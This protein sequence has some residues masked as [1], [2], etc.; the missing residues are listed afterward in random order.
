MKILVLGASG[1]LGSTVIRYLLENDYD[2]HGTVRGSS[3][4]DLFPA[5][6]KKFIHGDVV[7]EDFEGILRLI[8]KIKPSIVINCIG[9]IKQ[10][11]DSFDPLIA[12]PINSLLPHKLARLCDLEGVR[13]IHI[14]TDCVFSGRKGG[15][16]EIDFP[17]ANDLYGRSK[18]LGEVDCH[19]CITLRTSI[20]GHEL[21][22][23]NSL[24]DWFLSQNTSV[25]GYT[26]AI[27]SGLTTLEIAKVISNHVMPHKELSG[28]YHLS[29][30]SIN[31]YELLKLIAEV[32][33]KD[34]EII[35]SDE[36][37]IDRSLNSN[38]FCNVTGYIPKPWPQL[39]EEMHSFRRYD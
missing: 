11:G 13:L 34:I 22:T 18:Y 3:S 20:I 7:A 21:N 25:F 38:K 1:M 9:I 5:R 35:P 39:I 16:L 12:I 10:L 32:Y 27:F 30:N 14:S 23:S 8:K 19:N 26:K 36:T 24:L 29:V 4:I 31:K 15:Y 17:D 33:K 6:I 37:V 28:L 2:A